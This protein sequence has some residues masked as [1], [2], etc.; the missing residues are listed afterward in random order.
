MIDQGKHNVLGVRIN[1]IDYEASVEQVIRAAKA[2]RPMAVAALAVHG[3]MTGVFDPV[4]R[5]RLNRLDLAVPDGQPVRW[6][7]NWLHRTRLK[8]RVYG[9]TLMLKICEQAANEQLPIFLFG[10]TPE[11]LAALASSLAARFPQLTIAGT[12]CSKF[13]RLSVNERDETVAAI[14]AS[15]AAITFVGLGCPRQEVWAF[16]FRQPLS[17][18]V[19]AVGAAF[20]FHANQLPQAP[21]FMQDWGLEWLFRL[22]QEPRRLWRRYLLLNPVYLSLLLLQLARLRT[23]DPENVSE[24]TGDILHG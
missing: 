6:A 19:V 16:E 3:V 10:D 7:L 12:K 9:P 14:R 23:F 21:Q 15:G 24:P 11:V 2:R 1:A 17:M 13:R 18:P 22:A 20:R 8:D 5:F 4:H